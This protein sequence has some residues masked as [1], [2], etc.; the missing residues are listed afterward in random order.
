MYPQGYIKLFVVGLDAFCY[1]AVEM[2]VPKGSHTFLCPP[3]GTRTRDS[4]I[5]DNLESIL[6]FSQ[7]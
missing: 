7:D 6:K 4:T 2:S 1:W 5:C 3:G